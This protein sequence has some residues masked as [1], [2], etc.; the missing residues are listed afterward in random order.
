[1]QKELKFVYSFNYFSNSANANENKISPEG[2][3]AF[4]NSPTWLSS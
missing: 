3:D 2:M 4:E 1:M